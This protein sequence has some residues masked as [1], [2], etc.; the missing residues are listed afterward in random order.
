LTVKVKF[1]KGIPSLK[2]MIIGRKKIP[3]TINSLLGMFTIKSGNN[4]SNSEINLLRKG[5]KWRS[6]PSSTSISDKFFGHAYFPKDSPAKNKLKARLN[7]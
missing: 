2:S 4:F 7:F 1:G 6:R 3:A 5:Y